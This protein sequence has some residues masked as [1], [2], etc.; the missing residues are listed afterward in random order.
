MYEYDQHFI[1]KYFLESWK[2]LV[3]SSSE[4]CLFVL[5]RFGEEKLF[6][7]ALRRWPKY[8]AQL[9]KRKLIQFLM[10]LHSSYTAARGNL[11][12]I[13][14]WPSIN[15]AYIL[16]KQEEKQRQTQSITSSP[17]AMLAS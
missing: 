2:F 10:G 7:E 13:N 4:Y 1:R 9:E 15:Q 3:E 8:P 6:K 12:M 17:I 11:L 14:P 5:V 16:I